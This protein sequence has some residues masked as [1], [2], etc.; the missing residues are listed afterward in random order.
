[1]WHLPNAHNFHVLMNSMLPGTPFDERNYIEMQAFVPL[2][3]LPKDKKAPILLMGYSLKDSAAYYL[4][5]MLNLANYRNLYWY[6]GGREDWLR[7][8]RVLPDGKLPADVPVIAWTDLETSLNKVNLV[9]VQR[10]PQ[11]R[12]GHILG[13]VNNLYYAPNIPPPVGELSEWTFNGDNWN[14]PALPQDKSKPLVIVGLDET[15]WTAVIAT[16]R[17]IALGYKASWYKG[18]SAEW[19]SLKTWFGPER[20]PVATGN[21]AK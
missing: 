18:G 15:D 11:Y 14:I 13:A 2:S 9:S 16:K 6:R 3:Q 10:L 8:H 17:A 5:M 1:M 21:A 7:V 12:M 19:L 4:A 20:F